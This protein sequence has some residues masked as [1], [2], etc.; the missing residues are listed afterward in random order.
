MS[1]LVSI[2]RATPPHALKLLI[3]HGGRG[4]WQNTQLTYGTFVVGRDASCDIVIDDPD[5]SRE[6][7]HFI[8]SHG[9][10]VRFRDLGSTNG[11]FVAAQRHLE[12][13]L[14]NGHV[15]QLGPVT[16][17]RVLIPEDETATPVRR[18]ALE[19]VARSVTAPSHHEQFVAALL[20]LGDNSRI[21]LRE[22]STVETHL[23][24]ATG[25]SDRTLRR[26]VGD[27]LLQQQL[28]EVAR[29]HRYLELY[30]RLRGEERSGLRSF[31]A[32]LNETR[33]V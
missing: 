17:I 23:A 3:D 21:D 10:T 18:T 22:T 30:N 16:K 4:R 1:N 26:Y 7:L 12:G 5:V 20:A 31:P 9:A 2:S 33:Q 13:E 25:F 14:A 28:G 15:I 27:L 29:G 32:A 24:R 19:P 6:H 11:T 8:V